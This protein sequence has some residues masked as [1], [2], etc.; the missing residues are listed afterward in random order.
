MYATTSIE[1]QTKGYLS[2]IIK[3][4]NE[5]QV[6]LL[7][8][9]GLP[10][11]AEKIKI[12]AIRA[13][14][15]SVTSLT[16]MQIELQKNA[17]L[18]YDNL[19]KAASLLKEDKE[20]S[21]KLIEN[22]YE[23]VLESEGE[24]QQELERNKETKALFFNYSQQLHNSLL[25]LEKENAKLTLEA[26]K[27]RNKA[28]KFK[29]ERYYFLALGPFGAAG[30]ATATALFATWSDKANKANKAAS[31]SKARLKNLE[32]F[33]DNILRLQDGF[34]LNIEALSG[35]QNAL[36]F[37]KGNIENIENNTAGENNTALELFLHAAVKEASILVLDVA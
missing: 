14:E 13:I 31:R 23:I 8:I 20:T 3:N 21:N 5:H 26:Q 6:D 32:V 7:K 2:N 33:E 36:G 28:N 16:S 37:L 30:L 9:N 19:Q 24:L 18:I 17:H 12:D 25:A 15:E 34:S 27:A 10:N 1:P 29:K 22:T 35:V 11:D 4:T